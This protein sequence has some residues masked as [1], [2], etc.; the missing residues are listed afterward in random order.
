VPRI[1][2]REMDFAFRMPHRAAV[3]P[4]IGLKVTRNLSGA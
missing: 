1:D 4:G 3:A 2:L